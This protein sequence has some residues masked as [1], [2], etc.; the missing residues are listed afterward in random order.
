MRIIPEVFEPPSAGADTQRTNTEMEQEQ[1]DTSKQLAQQELN[2]ASGSHLDSPGSQEPLPQTVVPGGS[3][4][5]DHSHDSTSPIPE[6]N[7]SKPSTAHAEVER[8]TPT[9]VLTGVETGDPSTGS[10]G[11]SEDRDLSA[12]SSCVVSSQENL[13]DFDGS[14]DGASKATQVPTVVGSVKITEWGL[15]HN[16]SLRDEEGAPTA[17]DYTTT[18]PDISEE[19]DRLKSLSSGGGIAHEGQSREDQGRGEADLNDSVSTSGESSSESGSLP[20]GTNSLGGGLVFPQ[21]DAEALPGVNADS[22]LDAETDVPPKKAPEDSLDLLNFDLNLPPTAARPNA[23]ASSNGFDWWGEAFAETQNMT[24]DFDTLVEQLDENSPAP[25]AARARLSA[26]QSQQPSHGALKPAKSDSSIVDSVKS[27]G[28]VT[29]S[30]EQVLTGETGATGHR[31]SRSLLRR[32]SDQMNSSPT[33]SQ[34]SAG[35]DRKSSSATNSRSPSPSRRRNSPSI[36]DSNAYVIQAGRLIAKA[37]EFEQGKEWGDAFDLFKA[38]VDVL[39]NGVQSELA[40]P[41]VVLDPWTALPK[42]TEN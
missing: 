30:S 26:P 40:G 33:E 13:I 22:P 6:G 35:K 7:T 8:T 19:E 37:L 1:P 27:L 39:L 24:D 23:G 34:G 4:S 42:G 38:A 28:E 14:Y 12:V 11:V 10:R 15:E 36:S 25:G 2:G 32:L 18:L 21:G 17:P 41:A 9:D 16:L 29:S 20:A 3:S 31:K 5:R